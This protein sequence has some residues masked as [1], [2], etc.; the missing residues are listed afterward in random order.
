MIELDGDREIIENY[1]GSTVEE[2][3]EIIITQADLF[4]EET[5]IETQ[6]VDTDS[7]N[8]LEIPV[9]PYESDSLVLESHG[10]QAFNFEGAAQPLVEFGSLVS[11]EFDYITQTFNLDSIW[12][13]N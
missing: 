11:Q 8:A 13:G 6:A 2:H 4:P 9:G 5:V 1:V 7:L 10:T 12:P 3:K